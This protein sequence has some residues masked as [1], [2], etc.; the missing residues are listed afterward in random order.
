M[1]EGIDPRGLE[2]VG[3]LLQQEGFRVT[4]T[5]DPKGTLASSGVDVEALPPG[6]FETL[7]GLTPEELELVGKIQA[8]LAVALR[9]REGDFQ[10]ACIF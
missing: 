1:A 9:P 3:E 8:K 4:F 6:L 2:Q 5:R 10:V 7:A